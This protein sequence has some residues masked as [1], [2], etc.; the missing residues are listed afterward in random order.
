MGTRVS[1]AELQEELDAAEAR[2]MLLTE[3]ITAFE[4]RRVEAITRLTKLANRLHNEAPDYQT[5]QMWE[6]SLLDV[7]AVIRESADG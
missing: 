5:V 4:A 2:E 7:I 1:T 6:M 3:R